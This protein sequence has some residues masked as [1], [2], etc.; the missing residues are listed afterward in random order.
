MKKTA[1]VWSTTVLV[2]ATVACSQQSPA[3]PSEVA[4]AVADSPASA[5]RVV[6]DA[7]TG[8][9][10]SA[11][12]LSAPNDNQIFKF[13]QQP[14]TLTVRNAVST[15]T[16]PLTY[17]FQV[18][19]DAAFAS[20][21]FTQDGVA[22]G[23]NG[24]TSLVLGKLAGAKSYFWRA[25]VVSGAL[26]G[27][28]APPRS[29]S[30]GPEIVL[31]NPVLASPAQGATVSGNASLTVTNIQR[32]GP[33]TQI[34]YHFDMAD[35]S[36]FGHIVFTANVVEQAGG[37][38][39][40]SAP[41]NLAAGTY[42]WRV[43][44]AD[45]PSGVTTP[46]SAVFSFKFQPFDLSQATIINSP[47]D[48]ASWAETGKITSVFFN[49]DAFLV[50]FD[51][52]LA[53]NR[54]PDTPFGEGDLEYTLGMCLNINGHWYCSAVC[55]FWYGR[56]LEASGPP[57]EVAINWFYDV[58]WGIMQGYQPVDGETVGLFACAGNCRNN[59][60]GDASYVKE[61]TNV[62]FV[63]W[64]NGGGADYTFNSIGRRVTVSKKR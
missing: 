13:T 1:F 57:S 41:S 58:R 26:A 17:S 55:Q 50:D 16:T 32:S 40:V 12:T 61:R 35:S 27:P 2:A 63:Q 15:G 11:P 9:T 19:S 37:Q 3:R 25:R 48:L 46:F 28:Y 59:T 5:A 4:T 34:V 30:V 7:L 8:I 21:V 62:A 53:D 22:Q 23:A 43:S 54:W 20:L 31:Q 45:P 29:F 44:A 38:T 42:F 33:I 10:L 56:E 64:A 14:F 36:S 24:Q 47:F 52:R 18:A 39:S 49:P 60:A 51:I 6:T